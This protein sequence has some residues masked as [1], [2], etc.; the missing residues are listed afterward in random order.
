MD[1]LAHTHGLAPAL[2]STLLH[3]LWQVTLLAGVAALALRALSQASAAW[4]HALALVLL[5]AMV[6]VPAA[7]FLGLW[8]LPALQLTEG[9]L[10]S[11]AAPAPGTVSGVLLP[12]ASPLA[13]A[14]VL[15]WLAGVGLM[16]LRH[17]GGL[18]AVAALERGRFLPLPPHWQLRADE[19]RR[20]MGLARDV[21]VRLSDDVLSPCAA[22]LLRPVV[23]LP[24]SLLT[25]APAGQLEALLAHELAHVA[26]RDWLWNG[27]QCVV[28]SL[29]FFHPA[30][31]WLGRRVRQE[32][33]QA[34]D[35]L[36]VAACGDALALAEAL[37]ALERERHAAPRLVLAAHEG[38]LVRRVRRLLCRPPSQGRRGALALLGAITVAAALP[39]AQ[40]GLTGC[41]PPERH[42]QASTAGALGPGDYRQ[43]TT[44][45]PDG[46]RFYRASVDAQGRLSEVY[47]EDGQDRPI[48]AGVRR[49]IAANTPPEDLAPEG[50][51]LEELPEVRALLELVAVH[52]DVVARL[53][54]HALA[55]PGS[56]VGNLR[57]REHDGEADVRV[58]LDG[59]R[60]R[61]TLAIEA[62]W[63]GRS[64]TLQR[65]ALP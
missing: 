22:R 65:V 43:I 26:R 32:R 16:L 31:W 4:R 23:W 12:G 55:T 47:R 33:E 62:H 49:W 42:V 56:L 24:L 21:A 37:S 11:L 17:A 13:A 38:S 35:D 3:S 40:L 53:G 39:L 57:L 14:M 20:A 52:S 1:G 28:E 30:A 44:N 59:P 48:D 27:L 2:A 63:D 45:G 9:L 51:G 19:L 54:A 7:Q 41:H 25:R 61:A 46:Q 18:R 36:A 10:T 5:L 58:E 50:P 6:L 64:W 15:A 60:G 34:C 29:L 8:E